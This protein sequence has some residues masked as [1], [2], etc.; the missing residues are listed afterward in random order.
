MSRLLF[1]VAQDEPG[2]L[3]FLRRDF[4]AE[5]A[6]GEVEIFI[7][8]RQDRWWHDVQPRETEARDRNRN[9]A[10][11]ISF[12]DLGCAFVPHRPVFSQG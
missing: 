2:L 4:A 10:V 8:R 1:I 5:E 12:H 11:S 3:A 9:S 6:A 7:D